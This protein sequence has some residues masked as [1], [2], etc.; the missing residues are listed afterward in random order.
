MLG[1]VEFS[2]KMKPLQVSVYIC[3]Y[4]NLGIVNLHYELGG[5]SMNYGE[6]FSVMLVRIHGHFTI[7]S[8]SEIEL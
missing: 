1:Y 7:S 6:S 5:V 3:F 4:F 2:P 8:A